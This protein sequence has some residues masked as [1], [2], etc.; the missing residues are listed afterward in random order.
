MSTS[1]QIGISSILL[2]SFRTG[3]WFALSRAPLPVAT[4]RPNTS[5]CPQALSGIS[6]NTSTSSNG[7][8]P[9]PAHGRIGPTRALSVFT[10]DV[11]IQHVGIRQARRDVVGVF[12][13]GKH[14]HVL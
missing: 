9:V 3:R 5:G 7:V 11:G 4:E 6:P 10:E 12:G 2:F 8:D 14:E 13:G 1:S